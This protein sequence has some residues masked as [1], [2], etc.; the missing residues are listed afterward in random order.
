MPKKTAPEAPA[1][2]C[3]IASFVPVGGLGVALAS[4]Q[5]PWT[6][7][8]QG[9]FSLSDGAR[10]EI[11]GGIYIA[12]HP[13][14]GIAL[15]DLTPAEPAN[16]LPR[17]RQLLRATR[18][19][20]FLHDDPPLLGVALKRSD[21]EIAEKCLYDAFAGAGPC[22]IKDANWTGIAVN[23]LAAQYA[24]LMQ[25]KAA[26]AETPAAA[27]AETPPPAPEEIVAEPVEVANEEPAPAP[28]S[29][30]KR[31]F[32]RRAPKTPEPAEVANKEPAS[33]EDT[34][35]TKETVAGTALVP[36]AR[37]RAQTKAAL[38]A[39]CLATLNRLMRAAASGGRR[40]RLA[41]GAAWTA[42]REKRAAMTARAPRMAP[43]AP[44]PA[45][46]AE[47]IDAAPVLPAPPPHRIALPALRAARKGRFAWRG[48]SGAWR[49]RPVALWAVGG[50]L[51]AAAIV[52][53]VHA[54][55]ATD[56]AMLQRADAPSAAP[57]AHQIAAVAPPNMAV[58]LPAV[59]AAPKPSD[60]AAGAQAVAAREGTGAAPS[61]TRGP[62]K[63]AAAKAL[64]KHAKRPA[65]KAAPPQRAQAMIAS[66]V[67]EHAARA[68]TRAQRRS[69][70]P[71]DGPE[72]AYANR[73]AQ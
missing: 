67:W 64:A 39:A 29:P 41:F 14:K 57:P 48:I 40:A 26:A 35:Q 46:T 16:A 8:R 12:L 20:A 47:S 68:A 58:I 42:L 32:A 18:V 27:P 73:Q 51:S 34:V 33:A 54:R 7:F 9:G 13:E 66:P 59:Q 5:T 50:A 25:V 30:R 3:V 19:E 43:I 38:I 6:V 28:V 72:Y 65:K 69:I 61:D 56:P 23:A 63:N 36:L 2:Q 17:L 11:Y 71:Y 62:D 70:G 31:L 37:S 21:L 15:V 53:L 49:R 22:A 55:A 1:P 45:T 4:L 44:H 10:G 60:Q 24:E 52:L